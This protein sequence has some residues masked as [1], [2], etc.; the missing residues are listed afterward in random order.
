MWHSNITNKKAADRKSICQPLFVIYTPH[1]VENGGV[2]EKVISYYFLSFL[3]SSRETFKA[4]IF[5]S[6][7]LF[8][9]RSKATTASGA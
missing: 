8:F 2:Y 1:N 3:S 4:A 9:L 7:S 6:E 5:S